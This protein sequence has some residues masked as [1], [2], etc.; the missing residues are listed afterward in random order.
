MTVQ[1]DELAPADRQRLESLLIEFDRAWT[2]EALPARAAALE[3][4]DV[5]FRM[6][7]LVELVKIDLEY[8][9]S[10]GRRR[11]LE[12]YLHEFPQLQD[13]GAELRE[14]MLAELETRQQAGEAVDREEW[15]RRFP[16]HAASLAVGVESGGPADEQRRGGRTA[17]ETVFPGSQVDSTPEVALEFQGIPE[18]FGRYRIL[19][20]LGQGA[21]GDVYLAHDTQLDRQVALKVPIISDAD[22]AEFVARFYREAKAAAKLR[23]PNICPVFDVGEIDG[24]HFSTMAYIPGRP[25]A[26]YLA[27]GKPLPIRRAVEIVLRLACA[28]RHAHTAGVIHRDL[29]PKNVMIDQQGEPI[30]M[31]FGLARQMDVGGDIRM[32]KWGTIL[33]TPAYM[34][35]EQV[36]GDFGHVGPASD[37]YSL[38]VILYELLTGRLPYEGSVTE[39]I[40]QILNKDLQPVRPSKLRPELDRRLDAVCLKALA[41]HIR[42]RYASMGEFAA[43]LEAALSQRETAP[44]VA[45]AGSNTVRLRRRITCPHCWH[46]FSPEDVL[47]ISA[48]PDLRGDPLLGEDAQQRFLPTRFTVEGH[49]LDVKGVVCRNLA[50]PRCHL[51]VSRALLELEPQFLSILGA[52]F[53][54][55]SYFLAAMTWQLRK[56]LGRAFGLSFG[57]ADPA[58]NQILSEYEETLFLSSQEDRLVALRKTEKEGDLYNSV[59]FGERT[60]WYPRPFV[61]SI[62]PLEGHPAFAR[63]T[64]LSRALC[65]YDNA[66]EHF[67]PGGE[68]PS[69]PATQHLALS[70]ALLFLFDP[71]QHPRFRAACRPHSRDP[72]LAQQRWIHRQDQVLLEAAHRIRTYSGLPQNARDPR[73]LFIVVTK[74]DAW[75]SLAKCQP[76]DIDWVVRGVD[77]GEATLDVETLRSVSLQLRDI[78]LEHAPELIS[79]AESYS[80]D[81]TY[82]P[83]SSLGRSPELDAENGGLGIRPRDIN[84]MWAEVPMLYALHRTIPGLIPACHKDH[85]AG[86]ARAVRGLSALSEPERTERFSLSDGH[87]E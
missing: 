60:V 47:W 23:H 39:V 5:R 42:D 78:L 79:A 36:A 68:N 3:Q 54:G 30:V 2:P 35:P 13:L 25:L 51:S 81:V 18:E 33:G 19:R 53:S 48:H 17:H 38:G 64:R 85:H 7:A 45:E 55:K 70:R 12:S 62:Q 29:K 69:S 87:V 58:S 11:L 67:L 43:A 71:T 52:P 72:Q 14:L 83:V 49:A 22:P 21:M 50:C 74:Y 6:A 73:P 57:D 86:L 44:R 9:W 4:E 16:E 10:R 27:A 28:L 34:S 59:Q 1:L 8:Q 37:V 65:L 84:P 80:E 66:G 26:D 20:P 32:T 75:W 40:A 24:I 82:I 76:L 41:G 56:T 31:D 15:L 77:P 63:A 61:F 46:E